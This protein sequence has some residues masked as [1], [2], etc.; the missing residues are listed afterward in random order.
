METLLNME[1][2]SISII[3]AGMPVLETVGCIPKNK[4]VGEWP[5]ERAIGKK[6]H[7]EK[8]VL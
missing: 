6:V 5:Q 4:M 8:S 2:M 7:T 3:I 1:T